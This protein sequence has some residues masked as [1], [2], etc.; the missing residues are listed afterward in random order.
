MPRRKKKTPKKKEYV[1]IAY[2]PEDKYE[3]PVKLYSTFQETAEDLKIAI[4][5]VYDLVEHG[6]VFR[7]TNLRY[8]KVR[9]DY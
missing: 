6:Y 9:C 3:L 2:S 1:I 4:T 5:R 7:K 8:M